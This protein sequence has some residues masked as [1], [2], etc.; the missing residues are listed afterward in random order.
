MPLQPLSLVNNNN[1][2]N[3]KC[4]EYSSEQFQV[5]DCIKGL[6]S[7]IFHLNIHN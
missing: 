1:L 4:I 6:A 5:S 2:Y 7:S 3:E